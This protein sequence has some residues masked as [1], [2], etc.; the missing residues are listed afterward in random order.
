[1]LGR[2]IEITSPSDS[3]TSLLVSLPLEQ[4]EETRGS[5]GQ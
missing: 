1:M 5:E 2:R 3:G 4:V